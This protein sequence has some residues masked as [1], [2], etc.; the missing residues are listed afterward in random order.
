[1]LIRDLLNDK[2]IFKTFD[3]FMKLMIKMIVELTT[4]LKIF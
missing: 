1:M 4:V 3:E 2:N